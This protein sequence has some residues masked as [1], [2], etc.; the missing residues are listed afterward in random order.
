MHEAVYMITSNK[1][2]QQKEKDALGV[3]S[4]FCI[5]FLCS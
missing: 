1:I 3:L 2:V 4:Q 5:Q